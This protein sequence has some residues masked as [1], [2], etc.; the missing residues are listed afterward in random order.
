MKPMTK[1]P[2]QIARSSYQPKVPISLTGDVAIHEGK[3][4]QSVADQEDIKKLMDA[5]AYYDYIASREKK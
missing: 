3:V 2:L 4:T 5:A 1:S